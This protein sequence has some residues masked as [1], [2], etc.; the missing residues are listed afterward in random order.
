MARRKIYRFYNSNAGGALLISLAIMAM[1]MVAALIA[2]DTA[3]TDVDLSFNQLH[4]DQAFYVAEAGLQRAVNQLNDNNSWDTG[5]ASINFEEGVFSVAVIHSNIDTL[6]KDTVLIR[7]TGTVNAANANLEGLVV[8]EVWTP[9]QFAMFGD[10][11]LVMENNTCTDSYNSD[12][13]TFVSTYDTTGGDVASNGYID[14]I[15]TAI[16]GG[17]ASSAEPTGI[18]I[19]PTCT[20]R[21]DLNEGVPPYVLEPVPDFEFDAAHDLNSAPGGLSGSYT[22]DGITH[23][24]SMGTNEILTLSSGVYYFSSINVG[25][26]SQILLEPGA[27]VK[28]Y[29]DGDMT[30]Q[31]NTSVNPSEP[32]ASLLINSRGTILTMGMSIDIHAA[33]YSPDADVS[34]INAC[35]FYGSLV[36]ASVFVD[37]S[38]CV[39]Y[40]RALMDYAAGV[41]GKMILI[42][43]RQL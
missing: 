14:L 9:F 20:V 1:L 15:N 41:T 22:Y 13:G 43:W 25:A 16:V 42:A 6:T 10:T 2:V 18:D 35:E 23:E 31:S 29:L 30:L 39:H 37:N 34:L 28:I 19:C 21:G 26:N 27:E 8:P 17:D 32:P 3:Q 33:Y 40:D 7:S 12:S 4:A 24:L 5:Y 36:A 38:V 11:S